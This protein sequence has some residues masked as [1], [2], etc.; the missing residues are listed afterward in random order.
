[1]RAR[2]LLRT[3]SFVGFSL[4][5]A[6]V[7]CRRAAN[8]PQALP[9]VRVNVS[10]PVQE[11]IT[12]YA[13]FTAQ[14]AAV[15]SVEVR[16]R[17]SGYL[18][19]VNFP[20]GALVKKD[21]VLYVIDRRTYEA[22][23]KQAKA[24]VALDEA[25]LQLAESNL[26]RI[27]AVAKKGAST[28]QE[29]EQARASRSVS[30]AQVEADKADM[31]YQRLNLDFCEVKAPINGRIGRT[32][33]TLG[34]LVLAGGSAG[35]TNTNGTGANTG[36]N[37]NQSGGSGTLLTTIVSVDPIYAYFDVDE[38][39]VLRVR[40]MIREGKAK[41]ARDAKVYADLGL[42]NEPN[43][44]HRGRIDFINNQI[45]PRTGT[46]NIRA[47][48]P[49]KDEVLLPGLF[50]RV[51]VP[52]GEPHQAFLINDRAIDT[53]QAQKIVY[54]VGPDNKVSTRPIR[55]G[56]KYANLRVI[57]EGLQPGDRIVVDGLQFVRP[58]ITVEPNLIPMPREP[59]DDNAQTLSMPRETTGQQ[60]KK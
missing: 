57:D 59:P 15:D 55:P 26:S 50:A 47:V 7:A 32:L 5:M 48:F 53:D 33:V 41:S 36:A 4:A 22:Q 29:V 10:V 38:A 51:R 30:L 20:E 16:A 54:V 14:T 42:T 40:R 23:F 35:S 31:E 6:A 27:E 45:N 46:L 25:N 39:T 28:A 52:I 2:A 60:G 12:D 49:N 11:N 8:Q 58:G 56:A 24:K 17:V 9:A 13:E 1:M 43:F 19:K 21:D 37:G 18:E 44:P 34:N 3:A